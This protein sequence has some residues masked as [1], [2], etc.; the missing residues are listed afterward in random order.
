MLYDLVS[1]YKGIW[2]I[3]LKYNKSK[4]DSQK[5]KRKKKERGFVLETNII[6]LKCCLRKV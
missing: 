4:R 3:L 6:D 2:E 1:L 5:A